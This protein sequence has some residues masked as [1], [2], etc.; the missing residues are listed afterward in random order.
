MG[1]VIRRLICID[2]IRF[3]VSELSLLIQTYVHLS[4]INLLQQIFIITS[5]IDF[6]KMNISQNTRAYIS[7]ISVLKCDDDLD[8]S[9]S[10]EYT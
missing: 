9:S 10:S 4:I 3:L 8:I 1:Q 5:K 7:T 2:K 6:L